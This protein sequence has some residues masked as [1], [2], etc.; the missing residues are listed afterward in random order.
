MVTSGQVASIVDRCRAAAFTRTDGAMPWAE[1]T[2]VSPSGHVVLVLDEDGAA[3]LE[4]ADDVQVVH[5]LLA[6]VDRRA[7]EAERLLDRLDRALD[8]GAVAAG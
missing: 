8:A 3:S 6:D 2:T 1:K 4:V 5:D 7:V